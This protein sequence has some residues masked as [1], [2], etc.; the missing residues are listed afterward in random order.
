[1]SVALLADHWSN[2]INFFGN[3]VVRTLVFDYPGHTLPGHKHNYA[4]ANMILK[5]SVRLTVVE[6]NGRSYQRIHKAG[7]WLEVPAEATHELVA[8]ETGTVAYCIFAVRDKDG[9]IA[10]FVRAE[11]IA[12]ESYHERAVS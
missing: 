2:H 6:E 4:H 12:D 11:H 9:E 10:D 8:L 5:G 1:M 3:V 7:D